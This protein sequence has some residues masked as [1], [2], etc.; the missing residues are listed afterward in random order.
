MQESHRSQPPFVFFS[1]YSTMVLGRS[2]RA[3]VRETPF[4][5][6]GFVLKGFCGA[7]LPQLGF[8]GRAKEKTV[9]NLPMY[10][11][12]RNILWSLQAPEYFVEA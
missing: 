9:D 1:L 11:I 12:I 8:C 3:G 6:F 2:Q 4:W 7:S 10:G 5:V